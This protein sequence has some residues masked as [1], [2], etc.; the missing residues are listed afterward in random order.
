VLTPD[1]VGGIVVPMVTPLEADGATV[2]ERGVEMLVEFVV[3]QGVHG[4]FVAGT[5][6]EGA[7]LDDVQW[8][9]LVAET[10]RALRGRRPL[11]AGVL[12]PTTAHAVARAR[13]AAD[14]GADAVVATAPYYYPP[15]ADELLRHFRAVADATPLPVVLYTIPQ[16]TKVDIPLAVCRELAADLRVI[17]LKDSSGDVTRF[18]RWVGVLRA[19]GRDFRMLLGTDLLTDVAVLVGAQGT[20]PSLGNVAGRGLVAVFDAASSGDWATAARRQDELSALTRIYDLAG[21]PPGGIIA[22]LKCAL[23]LL[24]IPVGPPAPPIRPV[25]PQGARHIEGLLRESGLL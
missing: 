9:R 15:D 2:S 6:G 13:R 10:G 24:G 22:G 21:P 19:G 1:R 11:L 16:T 14:L 12:G 3:A 23:N 25:D 8:G 20:V 18:R 5:T 17:G 7:A 4:L